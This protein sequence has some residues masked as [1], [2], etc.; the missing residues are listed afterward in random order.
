MGW[1]NKCVVNNPPKLKLVGFDFATPRQPM[2]NSIGNCQ[3]IS[4]QN[5]QVNRFKA[6][7]WVR[8][9]II[10]TSYT[11]HITFHVSQNL[12][13]ED[14][15]LTLEVNTRS[16]K[17]K[18]STSRKRTRTVNAQLINV[19]DNQAQQWQITWL[20]TDLGAKMLADDTEFSVSHF[21]LSG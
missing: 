6:T 8:N 16:L 12:Q 20:W 13:I 10:S 17:P 3:L 2:P 11:Y 14:L 15:V 1:A 9:H 18:S 4:Q 5:P 19:F 21:S 7:H